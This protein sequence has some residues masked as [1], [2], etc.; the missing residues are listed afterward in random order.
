MIGVGVSVLFVLFNGVM[1]FFGV[2]LV[3]VF[4]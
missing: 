3:L 1:V 2:D 4:E